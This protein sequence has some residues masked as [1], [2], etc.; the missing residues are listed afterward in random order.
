MSALAWCD[1]AYDWL[2]FLTDYGRRDGFV[3]ACHGVIAQVAPHVRV[4]DISHDVPPQD[5][6]HGAAVLAQTVPYLPQSVH[7]AVVDPE[8]G[9]ARRPVAIQTPNGIAVGPDNGLLIW[10]AEALGGIE[11]VVELANPNYL[12]RGSARTFDGRDVF[13]PAAAH[14][15]LG[16]PFTDL[17]PQVD[18]STLALLPQPLVQVGPLRLDTEVLTVDHFGNLQLAA[19]SGDLAQAGLQ[20]AELAVSAGRQTHLV[21]LVSAFAGVPVDDLLAY[22]DSADRV[23]LAVNGG[24]AAV[25]LGIGPGDLVRLSTAIRQ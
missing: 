20:V 1:V 9:T 17:G 3:A 11:S 12:R 5:V 15:A 25:R 18:A 23:A 7:L 8:V 24:S 4:I 2:S 10:A 19:R 22:V 14:L 6:R 16:V 21:P 13:S